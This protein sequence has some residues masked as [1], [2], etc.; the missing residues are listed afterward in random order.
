MKKYILAFGCFLM[1]ILPAF[2]Q[3]VLNS[4]VSPEYSKTNYRKVLVMAKISDKENQQMVEDHAVMALRDEGVNA[5]T[6]YLNFKEA[7]LASTEA[8]NARVD[9]LKVDAIVI[10][11]VLKEDTKV[12]NSPSLST[13]VGI[14]IRIGFISGFIGGNVPL[15]GGPKLID[16]L[17]L[18]SEFYSRNSETPHWNTV[19]EF[20][21]K[22]NYEAIAKGWTSKTVASLFK[23]K[24]L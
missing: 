7:D 19:Y 18:Q 6:S 10:F 5:I 17:Q 11:S 2:S 24:I 1:A 12:R 8:M 13:G 22:N 15:A 3:K 23:S 4:W 9:Q 21:V 16:V 14:P 20:K